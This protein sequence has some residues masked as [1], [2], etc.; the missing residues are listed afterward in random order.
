MILL[1]GTDLVKHFGPQPVLAGVSLEIRP[2]DKVG[3]V[4]PNGAG[5][6]TLLAILAG[7]LEADRGRVQVHPSCRVAYLEQQP[8][9]DTCRTL[10][11][12][13]ASA[14]AD[15]QDLARRAEQ[16]ARDVAEAVDEH[17]RERLAARFDRLQ[18][19]LAQRDAYHLDHKIERVLDGLGFAS[20]AFEQPVAQLSGG[21]LNRLLL[22]KLLLQEPDVMLLD[23]P[24]NHLDLE[25]SQW[26]EGYLAESRQALVVVSHDRYFLDR[27]TNRTFELFQGT[28]EDYPGNFSTYWRLKQERLLVQARAYERQQAYIEKA[29]E[30]IRRHHYGQKHAQAKDR[31]KKLARLERVAPPRKIE[32]P[33]MGFPPA[34]RTGDVVFRAEQLG[35]SYARPLFAGLSFCVARGERWGILGPNGSGKSTLLRLL[36]GEVQPD[37]GRVAHGAGTRIGYFDQAR[38]ILADDLSV[39]EAVRPEGMLMPEGQRRSLLARFGLVGDA[40]HQPVCRLSGGERSRA[41]LAR[42]AAASPNVLLLDEPTNHLDL[43]ACDALERSLLDFN[44]TVVFVSH[45]RYFLNRVADHLIVLEADRVRVVEGNYDTYEHLRRTAWAQ[46]AGGAALTCD[47]PSSRDGATGRETASR[48]DAASVN[49]LS[50]TGAND[51]GAAAGKV[52]GKPATARNSRASVRRQ[53]RFPY[54]KLADLEQEIFGLESRIGELHAALADPEVLRDGSRVRAVR[55]ELEDR[56]KSLQLL[57]EHWEEAVERN[58]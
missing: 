2:Q 25:A 4:G 24:S 22:A 19:E 1:A 34:D 27:V 37:E 13:A 42:L 28:I 11:D 52:C 56:Q 15:L 20:A 10:W 7:R 38:R 3:L 53:W 41:A 5:K 32:A 45:D 18:Q 33:A 9:F 58:A 31:E 6:T 43:W 17:E 35:K 30:F 39:L 54:R 23:E 14:L 46:P 47:A 40:V 21:Q 26:L 44:G 49:D 29:E 51:S 16:A 12:E 50:S 55:A 36:V 8:R 48:G 57:Y